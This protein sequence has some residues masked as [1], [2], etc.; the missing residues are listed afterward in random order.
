MSHHSGNANAPKPRVRWNPIVQLRAPSPGSTSRPIQRRNDI[1]CLRETLPPWPLTRDQARTADAR[2]KRLCERLDALLDAPVRSSKLSPTCTRL[3]VMGAWAF[4]ADSAL[5]RIS[6]GPL[7]ESGCLSPISAPFEVGIPLE[8]S[9]WIPSLLRRLGVGFVVQRDVFLSAAGEEEWD[10]WLLGTVKD[11][12]RHEV[13]FQSLRRDRLAYA[14]G[15]PRDIIGMAL[16]SRTRPVGRLLDS[17]LLNIVWQREVLFRQ[18]ARENPQLMPL[19]AAL[20]SER[21]PCAEIGDPVQALKHY[22]RSAGVSEAGWRYVAHH[23][24]RVFRIPWS[25]HGGDSPL[26]LAA[27]CMRILDDAGLPPVPPP[28]I[29]DVL[30]RGQP[31]LRAAG[32]LPPRTEAARFPTDVLRAGLLEAD[33]RRRSNRLGDF[34]VEFS[35]VC[36]WASSPFSSADAKSCDGNWRRLV[37]AFQRS[38]EEE[39]ALWNSKRLRWRCSLPGFDAGALMIVPL[40]SSE[41]LVREGLAMRNCLDTYQERCFS[42]EY[43]IYSVRDRNTRKSRACIGL[44]RRQDGKRFSVDQVKGY[45]NRSP[46]SDVL[47]ATQRL[48]RRLADLAGSGENHR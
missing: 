24:A 38:Q 26:E 27:L 28:S 31:E 32:V 22:F 1:A 33:R 36:E 23:G 12:L 39:I 47:H 42:R 25:I 40:E 45:A 13:R 10:R 43:E 16:A 15:I 34:W 8:E 17:F 37:R 29:A 46:G 41:D 20:L 44:F 11:F 7:S 9:D 5:R 30:W 4:E 18:T 2:M 3:P 6:A 35:E 21:G 19:V 48:L 14:L